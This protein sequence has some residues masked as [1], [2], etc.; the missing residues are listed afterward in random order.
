M[1]DMEQY[2]QSYDRVN[3]I[4]AS[5]IVENKRQQL[6]TESKFDLEFDN[7]ASGNLKTGIS[8]LPPTEL[9]PLFKKIMI[10]SSTY[11]MLSDKEEI[12]LEKD[13][14]RTEHEIKHLTQK[15]GT[16]RASLN[17]SVD[18]GSVKMTPSDLSNDK[19][20]SQMILLS[21][22]ES[23]LRKK[24]S[25][26]ISIKKKISEHQISV[27]RDSIDY[28]LN[29][30]KFLDHSQLAT[31]KNQG[32]KSFNRDWI[33]SMSTSQIS[34]AHDEFIN[35][36][37]FILQK[38]Q[39][40][41][42][43]L[44]PRL[45]KNDD[46]NGIF[47]KALF[48]IFI[49]IFFHLLLLLL[50]P[51]IPIFCF[52][53]FEFFLLDTKD[54]F[55]NS[56]D[57]F[58]YFDDQITNVHP[59]PVLYS[60]LNKTRELLAKS[61]KDL[62][63][64]KSQSITRLNLIESNYKNK[65]KS[66]EKKVQILLGYVFRNNS[67]A[68]RAPEISKYGGSPMY[69]SEIYPNNL[70]ININ[71]HRSFPSK[72]SKN[73][74]RYSKVEP[75]KNRHMSTI[76][77]RPITFDSI[78][79]PKIS[80]SFLNPINAR[81]KTAESR[82]SSIF[83]HKSGRYRSKTLVGN[84]FHNSYSSGF[85]RSI[86]DKK[87]ASKFTYKNPRI[88][89]KIYRNKIKLIV[90]KQST[91]YPSESRSPNTLKS[92]NSIAS[93]TVEKPHNNNSSSFQA[94]LDLSKPITALDNLVDPKNPKTH[95]DHYRRASTLANL[96]TVKTTNESPLLNGSI[97]FGARKP[98]TAKRISLLKKNSNAS[99]LPTLP[100]LNT[101]QE[102]INNNLNDDSQMTI[103]LSKD[104]P[105]LLSID[106]KN[107]IQ[108]IY[109]QLNKPTVANNSNDSQQYNFVPTSTKTELIDERSFYS[110]NYSA[111]YY[112]GLYSDKIIDSSGQSNLKGLIKSSSQYMGY[113]P[114][115]LTVITENQVDVP[116]RRSK[117]VCDNCEKS[118][119][120]PNQSIKNQMNV[121][122]RSGS[123]KS[124]PSLNLNNNLSVFNN[125]EISS[126]NSTFEEKNKNEYS[127]HD[128]NESD[129]PEI[130]SLTNSASSGNSESSQILNFFKDSKFSSV[131]LDKSSFKYFSD[132]SALATPEDVNCDNEIFFFHPVLKRSLS[133]PSSDIIKCDQ[134]NTNNSKTSPGTK[135]APRSVTAPPK[136]A[137]LFEKLALGNSEEKIYSQLF[138]PSGDYKKIPKKT[139]FESRKYTDDHPMP[140]LPLKFLQMNHDKTLNKSVS[141]STLGSEEVSS[142]YFN[143]DPL[144]ENPEKSDTNLQESKDN[145]LNSIEFS[146]N[147]F[148]IPIKKEPFIENLEIANSNSNE[149]NVSQNEIE[150]NRLAGSKVASARLTSIK[151]KVLMPENN[152]SKLIKSFINSSIAQLNI[153]NF[154]DPNGSIENFIRAD[155]DKEYKNFNVSTN[156]LG[157]EYNQTQELSPNF[158]ASNQKN[159]SK[160]F[161]I[162]SIPKDGSI[163][164]NNSQKLQGI[165]SGINF[166]TYS[167]FPKYNLNSIN[168]VL[169]DMKSYGFNGNKIDGFDPTARKLALENIGKKRFY[170]ALSN[171][172]FDA[173]NSQ[174]INSPTKNSYNFK[175]PENEANYK[176]LSIP[177]N[178]TDVESNMVKSIGIT[179][180]NF[181]LDLSDDSER[182]IL[183]IEGS[184]SWLMLAQKGNS[185]NENLLSL[186]LSSNKIDQIDQIVLSDYFQYSD[187]KNSM[188]EMEQVE[189]NQEAT[190]NFPM[191]FNN[192]SHAQLNEFPIMDFSGDSR[193]N[194][195]DTAESSPIKSIIIDIDPNS[196]S[197]IDYKPTESTSTSKQIKT[198]N[199]K[200]SD[201]STTQN[202]FKKIR[203]TTFKSSFKSYIK[204]LKK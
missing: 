44:S 75:P 151:T 170:P 174:S 27:L 167:S 25:R 20:A 193:L 50:V 81:K 32:L 162:S 9:T 56:Q 152:S 199:F 159:S 155:E 183:S 157:Y 2:I 33:N 38:V 7:R 41:I 90:P 103:K 154:I 22:L 178:S 114:T 34:P 135:S 130:V 195:S 140:N 123:T 76:L 108:L 191:L 176:E 53:Y 78:S 146:T 8:A 58:R 30:S 69:N 29:S 99:N 16:I 88:N 142:Y 65:V 144:F 94:D 55:F 67:T 190:D 175:N 198:F 150:S 42:L 84:N 132:K 24:L 36:D 49:Y 187:K 39:D 15:V 164:S 145:I 138:P 37:L 96:S 62:E 181:E 109:P 169:V 136:H 93:T 153:N 74:K 203:P 161:S 184:K 186:Q 14:E 166:S 86:L 3:F 107:S 72:N 31:G 201:E 127:I 185:I 82:S 171:D 143:S 70:K 134:S 113:K 61:N 89:S 45:Q 80:S 118:F 200:S 196:P 168:L 85:T 194:S 177:S 17:L 137:N 125:S 52:T 182:D 124:R 158:T 5:S 51:L 197:M 192:N 115:G 54:G 1:S 6:L 19:I 165:D 120:E 92:I 141:K 100:N 202:L 59:S 28:H 46:S 188:I 26:S 91:S 83:S 105:E 122:Y 95:K 163:T 97:D 110:G 173:H 117:N 116:D 60:E 102:V 48:I 148:F 10:E 156:M 63:N 204:K 18:D 149:T 98:K 66:L 79:F 101:S 128:I 64:Y 131:K 112:S 189:F 180:N 23:G 172:M 133:N 106:T 87:V 68:H 57:S 139:V 119:I 43:N 4:T 40:S 12:I 126:D 47:I 21:H 11:N 104:K 73:F 77:T 71:K 35:N 160:F 129:I 121:I 179:P 13:L 147:N 111:S